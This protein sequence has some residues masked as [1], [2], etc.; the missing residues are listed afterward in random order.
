MFC[1]LGYRAVTFCYRFVT[2]TGSCTFYPLGYK[3][4]TIFYKM[5]QREIPAAMYVSGRAFAAGMDYRLCIFREV[6]DYRL[7]R[8]LLRQKC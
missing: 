1:R 6:K 4:V 8:C 2:L 5:L 7:S 3:S